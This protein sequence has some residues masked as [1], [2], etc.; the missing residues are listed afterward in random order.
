MSNKIID[1]NER[2]L[3]TFIKKNRPPVEIRDKL[4]LGYK[5]DDGVIELFERRPIWDNPTEY[6]NSSFAKIKFIKSVKIWK[7]YWMRASGKWQSYKPFPESSY[8]NE[9]LTIIEE[10]SY[11][12]F[13]G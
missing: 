6:E 13:Y 7:L 12:C 5:Y 9:L 11:G 2:T 8:L 3:Q 1:I 10:D 4:D